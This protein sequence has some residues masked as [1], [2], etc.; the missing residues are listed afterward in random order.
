MALVRRRNQQQQGAP[1]ARFQDE[2]NDLFG[3]FFEDFPLAGL[4]RTGAWFPPLEISEREDAVV[5]QAELPGMNREDIDI[6]V[7]D[8]HLTL[9]GEK[10][11]T[12]E[13]QE[14]D[15][16]HSERR[17]GTFRREIPLPAG[18][19]ADNVDANYRDGV[20]TVTLPKSEEAKPRKIEIKS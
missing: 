14:G 13:Q 2:M 15:F 7:Q 4:S 1:L 12:E 19:D 9:T 3:R 18:V 17:Y 16:Y 5:V 20:L 6:S 8:N 10:K 11:E